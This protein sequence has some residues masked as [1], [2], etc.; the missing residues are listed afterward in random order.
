M[1]TIR[2]RTRQRL[3]APESLEAIWD[4]GLP[5]PEWAFLPGDHR[6]EL[7]EL[8]FFSTDAGPYMFAQDHPHYAEWMQALHSSRDRQA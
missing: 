2:R 8:A 3:N 1:S 7:S 6:E 5:P 4:A